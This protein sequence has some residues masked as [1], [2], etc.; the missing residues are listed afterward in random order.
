MSDIPVADAPVIDAPVGTDAV[1][2]GEPAPSS[3][4]S[5][6]LSPEAYAAELKRARD[7]AA[8][9]RVKSRRY[10]QA[11]E[12]YAE[13]EVE[14]ALE[15]YKAIQA[16][17][18]AALEKFSDTTERLR[19]HLADTGQLSE[20][21]TEKGPEYLTRADLTKIENERAQENAVQGV[22]KEAA[23]LGYTDG[24]RAHAAL[25]LAARDE[26]NGDLKA[27]HEKIVAELDAVKKAGVAEYL[28]TL[29]GDQRHPPV[30]ASSAGAPVGSAPPA[31]VSAKKSA[32]ERLTQAGF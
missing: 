22:L 5:G 4:A 8:E 24:T 26:T 3:Q 29:N 28:A 19:K 21:A 2:T 11:F 23:S 1:P 17:P 9:S 30:T 7:E 15:M 13:D 14:Y 10:E 27:A 12:G 18:K 31:K 20:Q 32:L 25:L 6:N 16:D